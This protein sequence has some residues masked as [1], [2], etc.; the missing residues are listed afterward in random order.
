LNKK[1]KQKKISFVLSIFLWGTTSSS[2]VL[3]L[4]NQS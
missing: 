2:M 4:V 3:V 1:T